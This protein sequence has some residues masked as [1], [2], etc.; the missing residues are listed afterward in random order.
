MSFLRS[1]ITGSVHNRILVNLL[2]WC[3]VVGG[4]MATRGMIR[5][6]FPQVFTDHVAIE[7]VYPGANPEDVE[8]TICIPIEEAV[9]GIAG[10]VE[11]SSSA[12]ENM[13]TVWL[14]LQRRVKN[15]DTIV[16]EV[17]DRV[18]QITSFPPEAKKPVVSEKIIRTEVANIAVF[19]DASERTLKR[20]AQEVKNDLVVQGIANQVTLLGARED[21]IIIELSEEALQAY[22]LSLASVL[23]FVTRSSLDLPAGVIRTAEEELTLRVVG[24]RYSA[25]EY[26]SL[27][28]LEHEGGVV[29]LGDIATISDGFEE[30]AVRGRF[31]GKPAV[32]VSV[33]K[34]PTQDTTN[35]ARRVHEYV[36]ARQATLPDRIQFS[37]WGDASTDIAGRT[38]L[39]INNGL[40]GIGLLFLTLAVFIGFRYAFWVSADLP[41]CFAGS[42][43]LMYFL[44][45]SINMV[46]LFALIIVAGIIVDDSIVIAE[47]VHAKRKEGL[48]PQQAAI[49]GTLLVAKPVVA[50]TLTT[51]IAFVPLMFVEGIMGR[52]VMPIPIIV[53]AALVASSIDAFCIL[54]SHLAH[55]SD[56]HSAKLGQTRIRLWIDRTFEAFVIRW[57]RPVYRKCIDARYVTIAISFGVLLVAAGF[58][59]GGRLP[60]TLLPKEDGN[61][62]RARI[63]FPEGTPASVAG[64]TIERIE[65]A[66]WELN[67]QPELKP[68]S[69]G[70]LVRQVYSV[71]GEFNDFHSIRGSNLGEVRVELMQ[72]DKRALDDDKIIAV[73]RKFIGEVSDA[74]E[75][76]I[77]RQQLGPTGHPLEVRLLSD[78]MADLEAASETLMAKLREF[79]G[80][81][82]V[83]DD[84]IPGKRELKVKLLPGARS[85]GLTVEDVARQLRYAFF[86]GEAV[87]LRRGRDEVTVRVR[88]EDDERQSVA[89]MERMLIEGPGGKKVPFAEVAEIERGRGF[90]QIMHQDN[91]RRVRVMADIDESTANAEQILQTLERDFLGSLAREYPGMDITFG[92]DRKAIGESMQSLFT[93]FI[94]STLVMYTM[95]AAMLKSYVQPL[96][97]FITIPFGGIGAVLGHFILG[98]DLTMMSLFG[99]VALSG[100]VVD[101][102]IIVIDAAHEKLREGASLIDAIH[103]AGEVRFTAI[104]L[105]AITDTAGLFP[106][107][108]VTHGQAQSVMPM[109][110]A[111]SF[112]LVFSAVVTVLLVP[113][114]YVAVND[115]RRFLRWFWRGG[116]YPTAEA[117]EE[118]T[119]TEMAIA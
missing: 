59:A 39:L 103:H 1:I 73:W 99:L 18:D 35:I 55:L 87:K 68:A 4:I 54:P 44:G 46:S 51:V 9:A 11:V 43:I 25:A 89:Q 13:G 84:L 97:I 96:V 24:Q 74:A 41:L 40:Q 80:V 104:I 93:G 19:G 108:I 26:E 22:N 111:F 116:E 70:E 28:V 2:M 64:D 100:I 48:S 31:N 90:A 52:F 113:A 15:T 88:M 110:I 53:I 105:S 23:A 109:A 6:S 117:V 37:V 3:L 94:L 47:T 67:G 12:N 91:K 29:R 65:S 16:K 63:R 75:M 83:Y 21:E 61:I 58:I 95:L 101:H 14:M 81:T 17:K 5:E 118:A 86:G 76:T 57:Y 45:Q 114:I 66:A 20:L 98:Y 115:A 106:L 78:S 8:R 56:K 71:A 7:V 119:H 85:L 69:K 10:V 33:F 82:N 34:T 49:E 79:G 30:A 62:L 112:G 42:L 38:Q 27:I 50:A 36:A 72:A 77:G 60:F 92:G 32:I 107:L 102:A